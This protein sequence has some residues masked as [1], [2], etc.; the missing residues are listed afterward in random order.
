[1]RW[2]NFSSS[3]FYASEMIERVDNSLYAYAD[4]STLLVVVH[5]PADRPVA[6][7]SINRDLARIQ[8]WYNHRA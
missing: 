1:M 5:K 4:D 8:E 6:A 7:A 3:L 2:V